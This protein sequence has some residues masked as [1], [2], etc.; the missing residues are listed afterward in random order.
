MWIIAEW[1]TSDEEQI[2]SGQFDPW[3]QLCPV[4]VQAAPE[5]SIYG[6]EQL[7]RNS[8]ECLQTGFLSSQEAFEKGFRVG[9]T[10]GCD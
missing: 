6:V 2:V 9:I 7:P 10:A 3:K 5:Y 1:P 8:N 4:I